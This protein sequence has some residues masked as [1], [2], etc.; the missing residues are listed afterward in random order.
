MHP[1]LKLL[2]LLI[3]IVGL[4][5]ALA[6]SVNIRNALINEQAEEAK[7]VAPPQATGTQAVAPQPLDH[8]SC[9]AAGGKWNE[10]GSLCRGK[11]VGTVCAQLCIP[12]CECAVNSQ[13]C[14]KGFECSSEIPG[15][16]GMCRTARIVTIKNPVIAPS[17]EFA[18]ADGIT[19]VV[20]AGLKLSNPFEVSG[21]STAFEN[22]IAWDVRQA[23]G[24]V[25]ASGSAYVHSPDAGIP[26]PFAFKGFYDAVPTSASGTL[27]VFEASAKDGSPI[28][29]VSIP[30]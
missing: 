5:V 25:V 24:K 28:H 15:G 11:P 2:I 12:Q 3:V 26:G 10:C 29:E 4:A 6:L 16:E 19:S 20:L 17:F 1:R 7:P 13:G 21:T 27:E 18:S 22:S 8:A 14:P 30:V 9:A 23:D